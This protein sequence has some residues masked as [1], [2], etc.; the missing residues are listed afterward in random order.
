VDLDKGVHKVMKKTTYT[1]GV[2]GD[3][4]PNEK[5]TTKDAIHNVDVQTNSKA[6]PYEKNSRRADPSNA[7]RTLTVGF[8][9]GAEKGT[10][11]Q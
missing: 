1:I 2:Q 7:N 3:D 11:D 5:L 8:G 9:F 4:A 10:K 6:P